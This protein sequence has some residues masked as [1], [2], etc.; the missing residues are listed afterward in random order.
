[1][2]TFERRNMFRL[3]VVLIVV[4]GLVLIATLTPV[5]PWLSGVFGLAEETPQPVVTP[6]EP[7]QPAEPTQ[8]TE[9]PQPAEI[10][11]PEN[12]LIFSEKELQDKVDGLVD[13]ANQSGKAKI[14]YIRVKLEQDKMLV[15]AKGEALGYQGETENLTVRFEE[16]TASISGKVSTFG[17]SLT[18]TAEVEIHTEEGKPS[19]EVKRFELGALP[20]TMLGLTEAK[21][22]GIINDAIE[23]REL[24]L[25]VDLESIR[26]EDGKLIV[27]YR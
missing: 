23:S 25:P 1:M 2:A 19:V 13:K 24:K 15:S 10:P 18:L 8:P 12:T 16:R 7:T 14:E 27:V 11:P 6:I 4:L 21:I 26:I 20:L 22:S 9:L 17:L 5:I 3:I